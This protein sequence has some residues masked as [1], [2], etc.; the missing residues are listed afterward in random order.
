MG[1]AAPPG[2]PP[3]ITHL[4]A[5]MATRPTSFTIASEQLR[6]HP[7]VASFILAGLSMPRNRRSILVASPM[8]SPRPK[9]QNSVPMQLLQVR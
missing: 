3:S 1:I 4:L 8:L 6:G 9:R 5:P 7:A 2:P